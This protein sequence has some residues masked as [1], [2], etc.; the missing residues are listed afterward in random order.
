M[1]YTKTQPTA[2]G[3]YWVLRPG[4]SGHRIA[5]VVPCDAMDK[6]PAGSLKL[7]FTNCEE[8]RGLD[9]YLFAGPIP[10]PH[11]DDAKTLGDDVAALKKGIAQAISILESAACG[12]R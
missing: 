4:D 11:P 7:S 2:P 1:H 10:P 9:G 3:F 12:I 8:S 5:E 6:R